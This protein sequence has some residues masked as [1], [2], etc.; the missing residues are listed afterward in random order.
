M[1]DYDRLNVM[2]IDYHSNGFKY[3]SKKQ[4]NDITKAVFIFT[5]GID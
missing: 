5:I 2:I 4:L 3:I 1:E